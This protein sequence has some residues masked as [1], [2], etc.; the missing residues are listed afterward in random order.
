MFRSKDT[1]E[2]LYCK[3][4]GTA[5]ESDDRITGYDEC[6]GKAIK[7]LINNKVCPYPHCKK[8]YGGRG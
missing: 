6:T 3:Y 4:C 7:P 2:K 1:R 8:R 5:L